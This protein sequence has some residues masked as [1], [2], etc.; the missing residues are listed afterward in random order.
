MILDLVRMKV[1]AARSKIVSIVITT[2]ISGL[3][4][5]IPVP[6][7]AA[8]CDPI[9]TIVGTQ[10]VLTFSD[11]GS[12]DWNVPAGISSVRVLVVGGGS[13]GGAGQAAVWWPQG[14]GGGAVVENSNFSIS[15]STIAVT[16]GAGGAAINTQ[17]AASTSV[18]NGGQSRFGTITANGGTAPTNTL[19]PGGTS[20]NGNGG[21]QSLGQYV[22]GGGGGAGG[23]GYG[24]TGGVGV[25]SDISGATLMYGSGGAGSSTNTGSV[26][27]GGGSNDN[28]PST[29]RGGGGSQPTGSSGLAS[30]GAAGVV[31]ISYSSSIISEPVE[32]AANCRAGVGIGGVAG[33]TANQAGH[34]CVL[35]KYSLSNKTYYQSFNYTGANQSWSSPSDVTSLTF[36]LLGAGGGAMNVAGRGP[37][38]SGGFATGTYAVSTPTTF[39][40]IVG[41]G[42]NGT[43]QSLDTYGGGGKADYGSGGGRSAIRLASGTE[44]LITAGGGGGGGYDAKCGGAGGGTTGQD[45]VIRTSNGEHGKGGTQTAGGAG[46]YSVNARTGGT[47]VKYQ[48]GLGRDDSGGGGG[49]Y[50]GGGGGGDNIG[51]GGG[52]GYSHPTLITSRSLVQ[53]TC[54]TPGN[55]ASLRFT[56]SYEG[57]NNSSGTAPTDTVINA[58]TSTTLATNSGSLV[59][60]GYT[61]GGWNTRA[62]GAGTTYA[63][64]LTNF[65]PPGDLTLYAL[66]NSTITYNANGAAGTVPTAVNL[67]G[68]ASSTFSLNSGSGL[69]KTGLNFAGWNTT[70]DGSG[71]NYLGGASYP[72]AGSATLYAIF[73]P[74]ISYNANGS[75]SGSVPST[76]TGPVP[77]TTCIAA[78]GYTN[79]KLFTYTG[80]DQ[81]FTIPAD[82]DTSKGVLVEAWGAGGGGS[83]AY[84]G[85][86]GG[87]AGGYSKATLTTPTVGEELKIVVGQGGLVRDQTAQ[88]GGG[89]SGGEGGQV[90][91]SGGGYSGIFTGTTPLLISGAG[92]GASP[93]SATNGT[94]GG[95]GGANQNGGQAGTAAV[96][97]RGGT[98]S[99]GG[100]GATGNTS[101]PTTGSLSRNGSYLQGGASCNQA[102]A[103][104]GGGG[105]GGFYGG[106]GGTY[107]TAGG[108]PENGGGGGGSGYLD[109]T[110]GTLITAVAGGNGVLSNFSYPD[111]TSVN[112]SNN[113]GRGGKAYTNTVAD[114][115][116]GNGL[117]VI[118]W[119]SSNPGLT[120]AGNTGNLVRTGYT[121]TGWN[122]AAN[123]TG[124]HYDTL[125]SIAP[126]SSL[127]L[128]AE[129]S[130]NNYAVTFNANGASGSMSN[131]AIV[132][133]TAKTLTANTF[134][135]TGYTFQGWTTN[136]DG[137]GTTYTN[138]Q[139]VT[140]FSNVTLYAKWLAGT[141][142]VTFGSNTASGSKLTTNNM[143]NQSFTAGTPF[144][145]SANVWYK[146]GFLFAG[147]GATTGTSTVVYTDQQQVTLYGAT[148][149]YAQWT[150]VFIVSYNANA[151]AGTFTGTVPSSTNSVDGAAVAIAT[152]SGNLAKSG[153]TFAG[154]NTK[155]DGTGQTYYPGSSISPTTNVTLYAMYLSA[156]NPT[157]TTA[158]GYVVL[159][160]TGVGNCLWATPAGV[161]SIDLLA[162][163]GGG[164][165]GSNLGG[166]GGQVI[167]Q[168]GLTPIGNNIISVGAGG[169]GGSG[170]FNVATN[171][172]KTG[173]RSGL[174]SS[175]LDQVALGG[176][177]GKGRLSASNINADLSPINSGWTGGGAAYPDTAAQAV[178]DPGA[179]GNV[180][181][182]G[183]GSSNGGG[184][185]GGAGGPGYASNATSNA[186]AGGIGVSNSISGTSTYYGGGGG[187]AL[188]GTN[189]RWT[190]T[191]GLGGGASAVAVGAGS[192]GTANTGGGGSAGYNTTGGS[193]GSGIVILRY[194]FGTPSA[195]TITSITGSANKLTVAFT[196]PASDGGSA[197][198]NYEYSLDGGST[199][200]AI[201]P[202][203]VTSP[204]E[205]TKLSNGTTTLTNGTTYQVAIRANN[206]KTGL[207]SN[208]VAGTTPLSPPTLSAV[209]G[210]ARATI[211][212]APAA[213]ESPTSFTVT[214]LDASGV[215]LNPAKTCT[216]TSPA[217]SCVLTGLTNGTPYKFSA[218]ANLGS[219]SS[220]A[221]TTSTGVTPAAPIVTYNANNGTVGPSNAATLD[222][223][224]NAGTPVVHPLPV[225]AG[226]NFTGWFNSSNTLIGQN[227]SNYEPAAT[228]TLTAGWAGVTYSIS[229]NGNGNTGGSS[230]AT[231]SYVNGSITPY[232]ISGNTNGLTKTGYTFDGWVD[233]TDTAKTGN[234]STGADLQLFAKWSPDVFRITYDINS[235]DSG[236]APSYQDYTYGESGVAL[237]TNSGFARTNYLF[238]GWSQSPTGTTVSSPFIPTAA[239]TLYARWAGATYSVSF[240]S[241]GGSLSPANMSYTTGGA[242][243]TLPSAGTRNG[244][245]FSGW[246]AAADGS[247]TSI[248][249][250]YAPTTDVT[251][252]AKWTA[253]QYN[254]TY[255]RG[256]IAG[257]AVPSTGQLTTFP[258][259]ST[260]TIST[261]I[262]LDSTIDTSTVVSPTTYIFT[263]WKEGGTNAVYKGGDAYRMPAADVTFTAQWVAVYTVSYILNGGAGAVPADLTRIDNYQESLTNVVPTRLGFNFSKWVDQKGLDVTS[264]FTVNADR[265]LLYAVWT[266]ITYKVTY[267][268]NGGSGGPS[269]TTDGNYGASVTL[270]STI[271]TR[272]SAFK[273]VGWKIGSTIYSVGGSYILTADVNAEAQ[274]ESTLSQ[275]FYDINGGTGTTPSPSV[276]TQGVA[277]TLPLVGTFSRAGYSLAGWIGG[278]VSTPA[279]TFT[280]STTSSVTLIAQW[281]LLAPS[282]PSA[283]TAVAG[284][285]SATVTVNPTN[286]G[287][288]ADS[289][290]VTASPGGATCTVYAPSTSCVI[291]GLE[292][293]RSYTFTSTATNSAGSASA[294]TASNSVIP[295]GKPSVVTGVSATAGNATAAV[296]FTAPASNGGAAIGSYTVTASTGQTCVIT[297]TFPNPL[298]C[299]VNGLANG[300]AVTFV[301]HANNG[302]YTSDTSTATIAI[303]P[304]TVPAAPTGVTATTNSPGKATITLSAPTDN[305]GSSIT[306]YVVTSSPGGFT[307]TTT[308]PTNGC[309]I[310]GL[311]NGTAYTF[312]AVAKN[313]VGSSVSSSPSGSITSIGKPSTPTNVVASAGNASAT[314]S[315]TAPNNGG[316]AITSYQVEAYDENGVAISPA[317]SCTLNVPFPTPLACTFANNLANGLKYSF[318][319][320]AS[321][322]IGTS[323]SSTATSVITPA[324]LIPPTAD[325]VL[326]PT[327]ETTIGAL[328]TSSV[329]FGGFPTPTITYVWERCTTA[330]ATSCTIISGATNDTY[331]T[332]SADNGFYIR[333]KATGTNTGGTAVGISS[334]T[335]KITDNP[336]L[337]APTSGLSG[338]TGTVFSLAAIVSG[339][340][341]PYTFGIS[342]GVLPA[343]LTLDP[344]T[345]TISGTPTAA[346]TSA[347]NLLV[348]DSKGKEAT[349]VFTIV[350][351]A[352]ST[353]V[354]PTPEPSCN[355]ACRAE[356]RA[357][358][359]A[360]AAAD[361]A[362]SDAAAKVKADAAATSASSKAAADAAAAAAAAKAAVDKAAA[363]ALAQAAADAAAKAAAAQA[364]AAA[365]AQAA[366]AKAAAAA[367]AALKNSTTSAATKAAATKSANTAAATASAAVKAA[368]D[369]AATATKA[370]TTAAN[371]KKQVDIAINSLNSKTAAS[372]ASEQANAIAAAAKAAADAAAKAA[373]DAAAAAKATA[374]MAQKIA[375]DT[376]ARIATEQ[377]EAAEAAALAKIAADEAA[378]ATAE[379]VV[380]VAAATKASQEL[381][382][383]LA[384]KAVLAEQ[385]AKATNER[386]RGEIQKKIE[387][388]SS[389]V[390][391]VQKAVEVANTKA[392]QAVALQTT[393]VQNAEA[394]SREAQTQAAEAV[395]IK[396]ESTIKT[397]VATK[398]V[399]AAAVA[400]K[401]AAAAKA[402]AAKVPS[403]AVIATNPSTS[404]NKNSATATVTG[405]K[406]GQKVKVTVNVRGK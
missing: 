267:L 290:L 118:Q 358:A 335:A 34:G 376:A 130:P 247:G 274:W 106:G 251:L 325:Q 103:E 206:G 98:N 347:I 361:K 238:L 78:T 144:T 53:G 116:G 397:A 94:P 314:V 374:E 317:L 384:D 180:V 93:G 173:N 175:T 196:A 349:A 403:K 399:A 348:A 91:S 139:S 224:F 233:G 168:T 55:S 295:A 279:A 395:A 201:S 146:T 362:V 387:D 51:A 339:G 65:T 129:W 193:G 215:A 99:A 198:T 176:S 81:T 253:V 292:N 227:G 319:V 64:G 245:N 161:T 14:G 61:F 275:I 214:A 39:T 353:N 213:G 300:T 167:A 402:A 328:L 62:D 232:V 299:T 9:S 306:E 234:Y 105:G 149:I 332:I 44:D 243:L 389:R 216:V 323:D 383:V 344:S 210:N 284:S 153:L 236:A 375:A 277:V 84:Y 322:I 40:I 43:T 74:T 293:G 185:G 394:T 13:S 391:E 107:Q 128:F 304:A 330:A 115:S 68:S 163:G 177:G 237:R 231:G 346:V 342:V 86:P 183:A 218:V 42:G 356:E 85:D 142:A 114:N 171:H 75:N 273:F 184:G 239:T 4:V 271:P 250:G 113:A 59:R 97:G 15:S 230:P 88:Y 209:A 207:A 354:V 255:N 278:G 89:G 154:W 143:P 47:G 222:I 386:D 269:G 276:A 360:K 60:T 162:V 63:V 258:A 148:T 20:G 242:T 200:T 25:N 73:L 30:A 147:W 372:Q 46:G 133:G 8:S 302:A 137:T 286:T 126:S 112:Y 71:T 219:Q 70:A 289:Y 364:K 33:T 315:F 160:F 95:G 316:S 169:A 23:A 145:L 371:A 252:Y 202:A 248:S 305:G 343:G 90:G 101:C 21:G 336:A 223:P 400:T 166:G 208:V 359:E 280:N 1:N 174:V 195:P 225:R 117:I 199:W 352:A 102:N 87:G 308:N 392:E 22:S 368:A 385:A 32:L 370:Q 127:S 76:V 67:V 111:V 320:S 256:S 338:T 283:P 57:N 79:C 197:I 104:G 17:G 141:F 122:T 282:I 56:V 18:N 396:E 226:Y 157:K 109:S 24:T 172:G 186:A 382:Q 228:I 96:A 131:L 264:N 165:G 260:S 268:A 136:A 190:G 365:D 378:K 7:S 249:N 48:G 179:G 288:T 83:I 357:A 121:F 178:P 187:S 404:T 261:L 390:S 235:G 327:G 263:G 119:K 333:Y 406:P 331:T 36:Y 26:S 388:V 272:S 398:A 35:I 303:T 100:A 285:G 393:A 80:A 12:C 158:N 170:I 182:G 381:A 52:S 29:N 125:Q 312:S 181:L 66:W 297:P 77:G 291:Q 191:G 254:I 72:S 6:A 16:V 19:A 28:P 123:G 159:T 152:N 363:A 324:N 377:K 41:Q 138:S 311:T 229:Y 340:A 266:P 140:L 220:T 92:G 309:E 211:S 298:G 265:Y 246:Y 259:N 212:V 45:A 132:A 54:T 155:T 294:S 110:R 262:N 313:S 240:N 270:D 27:S 134:T 50:W 135:R 203:D 367:A 2:L 204:I 205:I 351:T 10:T 244:F 405:L 241:N 37:G 108:G 189:A 281:T 318:K 257:V 345:G 401:V 379:K 337:S 326:T 217:T 58:F 380:A 221:T 296:R 156:C 3:L 151:T 366:A 5:S 350:I 369:A 120:I 334:T 164:G 341:E 150:P 49:G 11:I 321:N 373:A 192:N 301:V 188:Y 287:G 31:I 355:A 307:C 69:T 82:I 38:G 194:A 310:T 329:Q 124:T